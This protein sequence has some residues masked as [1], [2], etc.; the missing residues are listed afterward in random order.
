MSKYRKLTTEELQPLEKD[1]ILFLASQGIS[2]DLWL[3]YK[4][5]D[6]NKVEEVIDAFSD[7]VFG[8]IYQKC[9]LFENVTRDAWLFYHL[10]DQQIRLMGLTIKDQGSIDLRTMRKQEIMAWFKDAPKGSANTISATKSMAKS[11]EEE[12]QLLL[13]MGS[14]ISENKAFYE[15]LVRVHE[16][17]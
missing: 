12:V 4:K 10:E 17:S 15:L 7:L 13:K 8:R 6:P 16:E 1:F 3:Q 9:D 5:N 11:R 2:A 14:T